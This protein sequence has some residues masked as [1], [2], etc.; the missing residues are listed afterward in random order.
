MRFGTF[1]F[2]QAA[3][4][5]THEEVVH[6]ELD[7]MEWTEERF[8]HDG[9]FF[10]AKDARVIPKPVQRPHPMIYQVC[11]SDSGVESTASRGWPML[12]SI[13]TGP[14][15]QILKRRDSYLEALRRH[16]RGETEIAG[17]MKNWGVSR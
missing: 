8:S 16:G 3:P 5:L 17:L 4:G 9:R 6:R 2:F 12:N 14:V 13:L 10:T 11:G 1:F 15:D 7:Q